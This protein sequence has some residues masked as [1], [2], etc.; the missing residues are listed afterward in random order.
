MIY[1]LLFDQEQLPGGL[2][3]FVWATTY[4]YYLQNVLVSG[5]PVGKHV[6]KRFV[7]P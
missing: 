7:E 5:Y 1:T 4:M 2:S 3:V 6:Y